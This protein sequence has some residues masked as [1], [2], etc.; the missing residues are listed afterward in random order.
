MVVCGL[1]EFARFFHEKFLCH[2]YVSPSRQDLV[3]HQH[4]QIWVGRASLNVP[5]HHAG[6]LLSLFIVGNIDKSKMDDLAG[7]P[8]AWF[9]ENLFHIVKKSRDVEHRRDPLVHDCLTVGSVLLSDRVLLSGNCYCMD[10]ELRDH[11]MGAIA[12]PLRVSTKYYYHFVKK[13]NHLPSAFF[14]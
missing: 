6:R 11:A 10:S 1:F 3:A 4:H 7:G 8:L 14:S 9:W 13:V 12:M 2:T 5:A